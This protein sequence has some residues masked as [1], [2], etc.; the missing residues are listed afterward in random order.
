MISLKQAYEQGS[1]RIAF[2]CIRPGVCRHIA[3]MSIESAIARWGETRLL[4]EIP[5]RC[6]KCGSRD[7]FSVRCEP[8]GR[9]GKR[10]RRD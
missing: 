7:H 5:A 2:Y 3:K 1:L 10:G 4:D 6:G 9:G 8:P